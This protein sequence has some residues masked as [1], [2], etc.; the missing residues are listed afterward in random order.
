MDSHHANSWYD[1]NSIATKAVAEN[2]ETKILW[3]IQYR[4]VMQARNSDTVV[5]DQEIN[6][7]YIYQLSYS[8]CQFGTHY[9]PIKKQ[10]NIG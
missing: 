3:D 2:T 4:N 9:W 10:E 7:T 8:Q 1:H 6:H 5:N